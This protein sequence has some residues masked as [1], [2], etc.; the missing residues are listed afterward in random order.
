[1]LDRFAFTRLVFTR[2]TCITA[3]C[4]AL[5]FAARL[6]LMAFWLVVMLLLFAE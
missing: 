6:R 2:L 4:A 1:M 5:R 3:G